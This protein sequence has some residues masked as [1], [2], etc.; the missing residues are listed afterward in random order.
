MM[1]ATVLYLTL[2]YRHLREMF[3]FL[4]LNLSIAMIMS[5]ILMMLSDCE[6]IRED[7][8][9]CFVIS[10]GIAFFYVATSALLTFLVLAMFLA[11][12]VGIIEGYTEVY[13]CLAWGLAFLEVG[14][15]VTFHLEDLGD[16]PR[17]M[18]GWA[19]EVKAFFWTFVLAGAIISVVLMLIVVCNISVSAMRKKTLVEEFSTLAYGLMVLS[20]LFLIAWIM[21]YFAYMRFTDSEVRDFYPAFTVLNSWMGIFAFVGVGLGSQRFTDLISGGIKARVIKYYNY[22]R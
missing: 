2:I 15:S 7:R 5:N 21:Y 12:T 17:C 4:A 13:L 11:T 18:I 14:I 1:E 20:S 10:T 6:A 16:D 9:A 3:H 19:N 8:H 22:M